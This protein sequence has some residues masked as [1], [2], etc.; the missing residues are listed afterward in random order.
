MAFDPSLGI[1]SK[2]P[3]LLR[4]LRFRRILGPW[5]LLFGDLSATELQGRGQRADVLPSGTVQCWK[6]QT[7]RCKNN[8]WTTVDTGFEYVHIGISNNCWHIIPWSIIWSCFISLTTK[9]TTAEPPDFVYLLQGSAV[10]PYD[11]N[12]VSVNMPAKPKKLFNMME[13]WMETDGKHRFQWC[14]VVLCTSFSGKHRP[15]L[16]Q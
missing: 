16:C 10:Q 6:T 5:L 3:L 4:P 14:M 2:A 7:E 1:W 8:I 15:F 9:N 13:K 12:Q 11:R